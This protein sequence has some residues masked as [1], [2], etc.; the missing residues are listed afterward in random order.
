MFLCPVHVLGLNTCKTKLKLRRLA[1]LR[2]I[3]DPRDSDW[4]NRKKAHENNSNEN[5]EVANTIYI[6]W[7]RRGNWHSEKGGKE[8]LLRM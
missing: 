6:I 8:P 7:L 5:L 4:S 1:F 3:C 2:D